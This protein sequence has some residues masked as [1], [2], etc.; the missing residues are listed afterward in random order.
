MTTNKTL[1]SVVLKGDKIMN[2][3]K[4][5]FNDNNIH[6]EITYVGCQPYFQDETEHRN[7]YELDI[8]DQVFQFGDSLRNTKMGI[9]PSLAAI[10]NCLIFEMI[11]DDTTFHEFCDDYGYNN[12]SIKAR[13]LYGRVKAQTRRVKL[14]LKESEINKISEILEEM[15]Y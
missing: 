5:Y 2:K 8:R 3:L 11:D 15:G 1:D 13:R 10:V 4:K 9:K 6:F 7:C 12:N 14:A